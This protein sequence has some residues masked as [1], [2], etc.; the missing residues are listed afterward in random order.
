[1]VVLQKKKKAMTVV[2]IAFLCGWWV[3]EKCPIPTK[4][5]K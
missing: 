4:T 5:P 1:M 2:I 3:F